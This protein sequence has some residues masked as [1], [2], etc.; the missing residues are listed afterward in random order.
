MPVLTLR[1]RPADSFSANSIPRDSPIFSGNQAHSARCFTST[2][3]SAPQQLSDASRS[4]SLRSAC[5]DDLLVF[6][7]Y[8]YAGA[9]SA[10]L[11]IMICS[12]PEVFAWSLLP[13]H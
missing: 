12:L 13:K 4:V 5:Y 11:V 1:L 9:A 3:S 7:R 2:K 8:S 10:N 6:R